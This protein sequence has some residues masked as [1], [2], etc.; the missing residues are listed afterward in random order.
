LWLR[1]LL[2]WLPWPLLGLRAI[3]LTL[4]LEDRRL[5]VLLVALVALQML[6]RTCRRLA[7]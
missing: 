7:A 5:I 4:L 2:R 3:V 1:R 6:R